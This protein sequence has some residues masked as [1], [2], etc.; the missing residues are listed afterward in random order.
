MEGWICELDL[1]SKPHMYLQILVVIRLT[2]MEI[3]I[4][5]YK[6]KIF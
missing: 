1:V 4:L 3:G 2:F 5:S 6:Y